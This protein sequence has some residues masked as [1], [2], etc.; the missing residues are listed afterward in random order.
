MAA[1]PIANNAHYSVLFK[2]KC[3]VL[4]LSVAQRWYSALSGLSFC[5]G[6]GMSK[7]TVGQASL[8]IEQTLV[9]SS[10]IGDDVAASDRA[11]SA[12]RTQHYRGAVA[13]RPIAK[14]LALAALLTC[15]AALA[16]GLSSPQHCERGGVA[17]VLTDC[18]GQ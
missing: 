11:K 9:S 6:V 16:S 10:R 8:R 1:L 5:R 2:N 14:F 7:R 18:G 13:L 17:D 15:A 3:N 4:Q 12:A